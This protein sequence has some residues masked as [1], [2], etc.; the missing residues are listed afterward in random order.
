MA[1]KAKKTTEMPWFSHF[2]P[3]LGKP[4]KAPENQWP[5]VS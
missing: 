2:R 3:V 1:K 5:L 4:V